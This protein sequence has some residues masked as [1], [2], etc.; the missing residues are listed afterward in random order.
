MKKH[1]LAKAALV[2]LA[3]ATV[4]GTGG[5]ADAGYRPNPTKKPTATC[6][7][8]PAACITV[9]KAGIRW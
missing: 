2:T 9:A 4:A 5:V 1:L 7:V 3:I 6:D 8:D